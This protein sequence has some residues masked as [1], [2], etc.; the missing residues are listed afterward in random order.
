M[1][2]CVLYAFLGYILIDTGDGDPIQQ[3]DELT[4][5]YAST[6]GW[7]RN[8]TKSLT[9]NETAVGIGRDCTLT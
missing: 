2:V 3:V 5:R 6:E 8:Y 9:E 7:I 1:T 4:V